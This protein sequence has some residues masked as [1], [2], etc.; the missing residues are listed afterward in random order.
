MLPA[1]P[2]WRSPSS[3]L[4][5]G[6]FRATALKDANVATKKAPAKPAKPRT[7]TPKHSIPYAKIAALYTSGKT[8]EQIAKAVNRF[9]ENSP[10]PTKSLRAIV[11][12]MIVKGYTSTDGKLVHLPKRDRKAAA[13]KVEPKPTT[14]KAAKKASKPKIMPVVG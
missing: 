6:R 2:T 10:D 12:N 1:L 7:P 14:K 5:S 8:M 9:N 11:S 4:A 13:K 3:A